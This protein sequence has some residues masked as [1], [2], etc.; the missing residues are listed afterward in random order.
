MK[1]YIDPP[2]GWRYGFPKILPDNIRGNDAVNEWLVSQG[3]PRHIIDQFKGEVP[4]GIWQ[5]EEDQ[6]S[7]GP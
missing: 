3:Y 7:V 6:S 1:M 5:A 4:C 2:E